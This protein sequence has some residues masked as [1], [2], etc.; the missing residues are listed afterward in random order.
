MA[1][2]ECGSV[3]G[4]PF[5]C[6]I[7][8]GPCQPLASVCDIC[9]LAPSGTNPDPCLNGGQVIC[10]QDIAT[11]LCAA[12]ELVWALTG[13]QFGLCRVKIRP[14]RKACNPCG[15]VGLDSFGYGF[16][17]PWM[18]MHTETGWINVPPCGCPGDCGCSALCEVDLPYPACCINEVKVDGVVLP[19][20]AY[21]V[22]NFKKL[23][24]VDGGCWP[25]CQEL[26][27]PDTEVGTFSIDVTYGKEPPMLVK[28][29]AG[30]LACELL[31]SCVGAP[32]Q[33]PQRVQTIS[34][35]GFSAS[36]LDPMD[37]VE[38]GKT[39]LYLVDMAIKAYNP[40]GLSRRSTVWSPDAGPKWRR[41]TGGACP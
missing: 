15:D 31:K 6:S 37:F 20:T 13:R 24:R 29:A 10:T 33:L 4:G 30:F 1:S 14:C 3:T 16:G 27:L 36:F 19:S 26:A 38:N 2:C 7:R 34:R 8:E 18:P 21:R 41:T 28:K 23:V 5:C 17:Y 35:Q 22:D 32:C 40:N 12:S 9:C 39:G 11:A 25:D